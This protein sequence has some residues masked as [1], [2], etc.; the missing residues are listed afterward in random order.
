M[1]QVRAMSVQPDTILIVDDDPETRALLRDQVFSA[2]NFRVFEAK[3]GPDALL[4]LGEHRPDLIILDLQLPGLSGHDALVALKAQGYSGPLIAIAE[5]ANRRPVV[6]AF[7]LGATDYLTRPIREAEVLAAAERGLAGVRL[8]HERDALITQLQQAN[9]QLEARVKELTTL[10]EIGQAVAALPDLESVLNHV[11]QGAITLTGADQSVLFLRDDK[12]GKLVLR[13][14]KNLPLAMLDRMGD[15]VQD[16]LADLVMTSREA[17]VA[18]GDSLRQFSLARDLYSVAYVPLAIQK[19]AVGVL[20]VGNHKTQTPFTD[21]HGRLLKVLADYAAIAIV[22]VRLSHLLEQ[23]GKAVETT[24]R[25]LREK[26]AQR[27]RQL[28]E[29]LTGL[30]QPLVAV[31][32][33]LIQ[34]AQNPG[35]P[36]DAGRKLAAL[37][38]RVRQLVTQ[39]TTLQ[40]GH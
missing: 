22:T 34:A 3:D 11:L 7:R 31:E 12:S 19:T 14:G 33:E 21:N 25:E 9:R 36:A 28:Q 23:R 20:A 1:A 13:G 24:I 26:D 39:I 8:R 17:L 18:A 32:A 30:H 10:Q 35:P 29:L 40:Q 5:E 15:P 2:K 16:K 37:A 27:N 38:H 6:D 4:R